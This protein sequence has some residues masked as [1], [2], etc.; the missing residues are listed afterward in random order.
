MRLT[1]RYSKETGREYALRMLKDNIIHLDLIPGSMLSENE[2]SSEMHL[3]RT[4]VREALIELSKVKIVEI[5]PQKGSAVALIDYNLVEEARFMRNV[6]ECA[7]V[8]L[9]CKMAG[10]DAVMKLRENVK[11]QEF[12]LENRSPEQLL[13]LDDEFHRLLFHITGK[14][15][16]YQLMDSITIHF[17]RIRSMSLIAVKDLKTISDHQSM[18]EAIAAKDGK[19]AKDVMEK[20]LSRYKI[21]EEALRRE[22]PGYF[23]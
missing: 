20:H 1:E 5:Y 18:V 11:L 13:K 15:Q 19:T 9:A 6:L 7:V 4:P 12:Y 21:D 14:D 17:D 10:E 2:L 22:Y 8:E 23:R 16:V 3:S